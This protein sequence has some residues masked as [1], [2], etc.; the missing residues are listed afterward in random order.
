[1]N[2]IPSGKTPAPK[3]LSGKIRLLRVKSGLRQA[4][5]ARALGL[6]RASIHAWETGKA[7]P[8]RDNIQKLINYFRIPADYFFDDE[9]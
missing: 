1:M 7:K 5:L 6:S 4:D 3:K 8:S 2:R 9:I